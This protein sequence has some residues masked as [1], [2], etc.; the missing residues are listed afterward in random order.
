MEES[1]A[2]KSLEFAKAYKDGQG[3]CGIIFFGGEPLLKRGLIHAVVARA[4]E[5]ERNSK[6]RFHF[7]V[8]TNGLLMDESFISFASR[9]GMHLAMSFDG[10]KESQDAHRKLK[11]GKG[12]Y[13]LLFEK[14]KMLIELKPYSSVMTVVNPDTAQYLGESVE[15][16]NDLGVRYHII[17]LNYAAPWKRRDFINLEKQYKKLSKLY[18]NWTEKG[19]KFYLSPFE[20]KLSSHINSHCFKEERCELAEK[21][22]SVDPEGHLFPCVQFTQAGKDSRYCIG[23]IDSGI[24]EE[25]KRAVHDESEADKQQCGGCSIR[26]RCLNTC[27]CLNWQTTGSINRVSPVLCRNEQIL[28]P[29]VDKLG[30]ELFSRKD[31]NFIHKH[32]NSAYPFLSLL[33]DTLMEKDNSG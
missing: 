33:E 9:V 18:L 19:K 28:M 21:Q 26:K 8:T 12:S 25:A 32:Y 10:I 13:N 23:N 5:M 6:I 31:P 1:T 24:D 3:S 14:L 17:S 2:F 7:K 16:L 30:A 22:I 11:N 20:V 27:G 29:I 15:F 4:K